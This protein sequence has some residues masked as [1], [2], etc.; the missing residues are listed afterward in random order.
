MAGTAA[1]ASVEMTD[2]LGGNCGFA[3]GR[4]DGLF[5]A[6]EEERWCF[7]R[8]SAKLTPSKAGGDPD[9]RRQ[10]RRDDGAPGFEGDNGTHLVGHRT[11]MGRPRVEG[12]GRVV[13]RVRGDAMIRKGFGRD[14]AA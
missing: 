7:A 9:S 12:G 2:F 10:G 14:D 11:K 3:F 8:C 6:G 4:D 1:S 13:V 5:L